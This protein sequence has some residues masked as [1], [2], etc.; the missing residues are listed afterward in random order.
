MRLEIIVSL[1]LAL[2]L[3]LPALAQNDRGSTEATVNAKTLRVDYGRPVLY[4]RDV[5][6]MAGVGSVWRLGADQAT[7]IET[8]GDLLVAGTRLK[9]GRYSLWAKKTGAQDWVLAFHPTT[10]VW[11]DPALQDGYVAEVPLLLGEAV[12]SAELLTI[13]LL[14][15]AG[16]AEIHIHWGHRTLTGSFGV[17]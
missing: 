6:S 9:A 2:S 3:S 11:G 5:L 13:R 12:E 15:K 16:Q 14:E 10:G 17:Q 7:E 8:S 4:G 1:I